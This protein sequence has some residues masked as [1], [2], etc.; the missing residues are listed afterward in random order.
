MLLQRLRVQAIEV[1]EAGHGGVTDQDQLE[2][3]LRWEINNGHELEHEAHRG[4]SQTNKESIEDTKVKTIIEVSLALEIVS[5]LL[6]FLLVR[7]R[8]LIVF[9]DS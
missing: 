5:I 2:S 6:S 9:I 4:L 8:V 1:A 3:V 7:W